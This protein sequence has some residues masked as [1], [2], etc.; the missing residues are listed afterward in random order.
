MHTS[1]LVD[2]QRGGG[3]TPQG[4]LW[5]NPPGGLHCL[6]LPGLRKL[7]LLRLRLG[8]GLLLRPPL[9]SCH[10][11]REASLGGSLGP[12]RASLGGWHVLQKAL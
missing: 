9:G 4:G 5:G 7:L 8:L 1:L 6:L 2:A 10:V 12:W 11:R 3:C